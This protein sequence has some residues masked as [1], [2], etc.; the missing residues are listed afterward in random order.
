MLIYNKLPHPIR[1]KKKVKRNINIEKKSA[2]E[3]YD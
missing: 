1:K 3:I 2:R